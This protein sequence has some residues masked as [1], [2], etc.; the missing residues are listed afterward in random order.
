MEKEFENAVKK[1]KKLLEDYSLSKNSFEKLTGLSTGTLNSWFNGKWKP[2]MRALMQIAECLGISLDDLISER[3]IIIAN[4]VFGDIKN[5]GS[6]RVN[7]VENNNSFNQSFKESEDEK[8]IIRKF[9]KLMKYN[10]DC[11]YD[12]VLDCVKRRAKFLLEP[13]TC[14]RIFGAEHPYFFLILENYERMTRMQKAGLSQIS[15]SIVVNNPECPYGY[16]TDEEVKII[17]ALRSLSV[18][19]NQDIADYIQTKINAKNENK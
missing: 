7:S 15:A 19:D 13:D 8:E 1:I 5:N 12:K 4:N 2:S 14:E 10:V 11:D 3:P 18:K 17:N 6:V 16:M 9:L